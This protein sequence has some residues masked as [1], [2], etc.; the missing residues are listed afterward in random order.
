MGLIGLDWVGFGW[1]GF[2]WFGLGWIGLNWI[3]LD[4][5]GLHLLVC[6]LVELYSKFSL[7]EYTLC[8]LTV[9][10]LALANP[11]WFHNDQGVCSKSSVGHHK[12]MTA[13]TARTPASGTHLACSLSQ[14]AWVIGSF[15]K[16]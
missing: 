8:I 4:W 10:L 6:D 3:A 16:G 9:H 2:N 13:L 11:Q 15:R 5:F 14:L 7:I 12:Q 1:I